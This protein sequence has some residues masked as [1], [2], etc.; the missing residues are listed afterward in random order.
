[1]MPCKSRLNYNYLLG[2]AT[3]VYQQKFWKDVNKEPLIF[4]DYVDF[5]DYLAD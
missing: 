1:M 2:R 4:V 5:A 3:P